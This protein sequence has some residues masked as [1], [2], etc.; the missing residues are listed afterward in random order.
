MWGTDQRV[1]LDLIGEV[2]GLL[3]LDELRV[4]ML[5]ALRRAVPSEWVSLNDVAADPEFTVVLIEPQFPPAAHALFARLA[6]E[7]PLVVRHQQTHDGRAYRFSDVV[8]LRELHSLAL[9]QEFY[10]PIGLEHQIAFTLPHGP[11][12]LLAIALSRGGHDYTDAERDLLNVARPFLIQAYRNAIEHTRLRDQLKRSTQLAETA[13]SQP[14][15]R[16]GLSAHGL[17]DREV[18]I[19]SWITTGRSNQ[20]IA[21]ALGISEGTVKKHLERAYRKL[22]VHTRSDAATLAWSL[23]ADE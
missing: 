3:E 11:T 13:P 23:A 2:Q 22:G 4:G 17:T 9:Y 10:G 15:L 20:R 18:E 6:H 14:T 7:N 19:I 8:T 1:L 5:A 16:S 21:D 12:R